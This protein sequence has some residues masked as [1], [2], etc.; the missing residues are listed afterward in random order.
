[1]SKNM[2]YFEKEDILYFKISE[3]EEVNSVEIKPNITV[4]LNKD[5]EIIGI[6]ILNASDYLRDSLFDTLQ[7]KM[8][9]LPKV[10]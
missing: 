1:M 6:E 5:G 2:K 9:N 8:L 3:D 10:S 4:E 7:A